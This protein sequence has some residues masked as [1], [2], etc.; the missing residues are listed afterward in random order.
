[1][2]EPD[3]RNRNGFLQMLTN[4]YILMMRN[5]QTSTEIMREFAISKRKYGNLLLGILMIQQ[6]RTESLFREFL[7]VNTDLSFL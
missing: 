2:Q 1:M 4:K 7:Q 5:E 6:N 3:K